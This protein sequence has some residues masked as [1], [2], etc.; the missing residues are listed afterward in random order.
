[1]SG[2]YLWVWK[3]EDVLIPR[4][5]EMDCGHILKINGTYG[6]F[7]RPLSILSIEESVLYGLLVGS[8]YRMMLCHQ[9]ICVSVARTKPKIYYND[10]D[11]HI[12]PHISISI[13]HVFDTRTARQ[14]DG[15][16]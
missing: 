13:L 3:H 6:N 10:R 1:M 8:I 15:I 7:W 11:V 9:L 14:K 5:I 2:I 16:E 12:E 4:V